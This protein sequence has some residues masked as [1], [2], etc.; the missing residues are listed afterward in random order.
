MGGTTRGAA[1]GLPA[2]VPY[3]SWG[4]FAL[5]DRV[6]PGSLSGAMMPDHPR[7]EPYPWGAA[8]TPYEGLGGDAGVRRL[9]DAFYD[10]IDATAPTLR[11]MLPRDDGGSR[12]KLYEFLAGWTGGPN[13][14]IERRGH[15]RLRMRHFPF[16]IGLEE[17]EEWLRCMTEALDE[18]GVEGALRDFLDGRFR[19][20]AHWLRNR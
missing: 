4:W 12:R 1:A 2:V 19:Q 20:S 17:V 5:G 8:A 16:A 11:A 6:D 7:S 14:Y 3:G 10:R 18:V 15:P 9:V 13:L